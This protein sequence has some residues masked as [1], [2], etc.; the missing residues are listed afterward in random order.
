[1]MRS[2]ANCRDLMLV[3]IDSWK[4]VPPTTIVPG[5]AVPFVSVKW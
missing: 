4:G 1:M 5:S 3:Q 2:R